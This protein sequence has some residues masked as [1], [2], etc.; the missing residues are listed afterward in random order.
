MCTQAVLLCGLDH[1]LVSSVLTGPAH[2]GGHHL[3]SVLKLVALRD[4][5]RPSDIMPLGGAWS[6]ALDGG[7]PA[8]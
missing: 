5:A 4:G 2:S 6:Q 3:S 8:K 7:S 1:T